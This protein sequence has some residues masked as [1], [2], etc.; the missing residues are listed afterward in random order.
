VEDGD[1]PCAVRHEEEIVGLVELSYFHVGACFKVHC[2][3][4]TG[5][6]LVAGLVHHSEQVEKGI[7]GGVEG[8]DHFFM[9]LLRL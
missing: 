5:N 9:K 7:P 6:V 4:K 3:G 8:H 1:L 2:T